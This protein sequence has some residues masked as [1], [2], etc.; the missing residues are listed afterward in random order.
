MMKEDE[1]AAINLL[2]LRGYDIQ[3]PAAVA[4]KSQR[5]RDLLPSEIIAAIKALDVTARAVLIAKIATG[6]IYE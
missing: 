5:N 4:A 1:A 6:E 3:D 2:L